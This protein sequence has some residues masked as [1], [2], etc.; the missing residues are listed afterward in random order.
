MTSANYESTAQT[1]AGQISEASTQEEE[2]LET[3][4]S[5]LK[6][7]QRA[8]LRKEIL[9]LRAELPQ[10][11]RLHKSS[12][13]CDEL[14][15]ALGLTCALLDCE[16]DTCTIA[17]YSA[18]E[19]E[20]QLDQFIRAAYA[21]GAQVAFPCMV[22][23]AWSVSNALPQT[24]EMRVVAQ[25]AYVSGS[26]PFLANPLKTYTHHDAELKAFPY[27]AGDELAMIV[28]PLVAFDAQRNRLG[29]GGGNYDR[30]L[31]QLSE[32]CRQ[33]GVAFSEQEVPLIPTEPYDVPVTVLAR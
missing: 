24:M 16:P 13:I 7:E 2:S 12:V 10:P 26:V 1:S 29:Y 27:I 6:A 3:A 28:I 20:V 25:E 19:E 32:S 4:G 9:A 21:A 18:F 17:V 23:D 33:I 31:P 22:S 8:A 5:S 11:Y 15:K 30:Y 14:E